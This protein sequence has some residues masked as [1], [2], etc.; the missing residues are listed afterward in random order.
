MEL[1]VG[2]GERGFERIDVGEEGSEIVDGEDEVLVV[3]LADFFDLG[4]F[5]AGEVAEVV[6][7]GFGVAGG[8][9]FSDEG[10]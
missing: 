4:F 10:T 9:G 2:I 1:G 7:E 3:S 6:V 5:G 8:E